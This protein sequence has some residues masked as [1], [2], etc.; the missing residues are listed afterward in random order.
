MVRIP[1]NFMTTAFHQV[2]WGLGQVRRCCRAVAGA[3]FFFS[4]VCFVGAR[5]MI[6]CP[7]C[8]L[9]AKLKY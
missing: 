2:R 3:G 8:C 9:V 4:S 5:S 1:Q 7:L 6:L